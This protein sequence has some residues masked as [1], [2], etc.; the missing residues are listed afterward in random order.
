MRPD[1]FWDYT[2]N[3]ILDVLAAMG[4]RERGRRKERILDGFILAEVAAADTAA[5]LTGSSAELPKPW[6][7]YPETFREE[8]EADER[9]RLEEYKEGRRAYIAELNR[10]RNG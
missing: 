4:R 3:E 7:Y 10:R 1:E 8:R 5:F 9:R 2:P 6:D